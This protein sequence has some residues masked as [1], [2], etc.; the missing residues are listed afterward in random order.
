[1]CEKREPSRRFNPYF[2]Q[3]RLAAVH[4]SVPGSTGSSP[5]TREDCAM[6]CRGF[7]LIEIMVALAVL[8]I[9]LAVGLPAFGGLIDS[10]RMDSNANSLLRSINQTRT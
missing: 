5:Y 3:P 8:A 4:F 2:Y 10:Q 6:R 7:T 9:L 1:M